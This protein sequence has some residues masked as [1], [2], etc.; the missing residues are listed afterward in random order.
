MALMGELPGRDQKV[1][2]LRI[3]EGLSFREVGIRL[4][5]SEAHARVIFSR[6]IARLRASPRADTLDRE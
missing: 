5:V 4:E 3:V 1:V 2:T 6:S